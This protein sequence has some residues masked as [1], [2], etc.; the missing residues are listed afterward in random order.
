MYSDEM[1]NGT[2]VLLISGVLPIILLKQQYNCALFIVDMIIALDISVLCT[3]GYIVLHPIAGLAKTPG[4][5]QHNNQPFR[6]AQYG[7]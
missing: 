2:R 7:F 4:H 3:D 1:K 5:K 6:R